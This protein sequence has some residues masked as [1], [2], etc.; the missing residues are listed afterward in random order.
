M[1]ALRKAGHSLMGSRRQQQAAHEDGT[2][3]KEG[4]DEELILV[5]TGGVEGADGQ[6]LG[7]G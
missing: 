4:S 6:G 7:R 1:M 5:R 3:E 2:R